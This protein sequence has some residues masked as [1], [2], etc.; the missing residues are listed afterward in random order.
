MKHPAE[1]IARSVRRRRLRRLAGAMPVALLVGLLAACSGSGKGASP[2]SSQAPN[3][4]ATAYDPN[5][6]LSYAA[7]M[8]DP[9]FFAFDPVKATIGDT[10][11]VLQLLDDSLLRQQPDGSLTPALAAAASIVNPQT[12]SVTLRPNVKFQDGTPLNSAAV[13]FTLLR[14][15]AANSIT[16]PAPIHDVSSVDLN[17]ELGLT[18]HLS[19]PDAGAFYPLLANMSTMPVSPTAVGRRDPNP[20][21]NPLGAGPFRITQYIPGQILVLT[22]NPTY[23][24]VEDIK[25]GGIK[26]VNESG[27]GPAAINALEAGT[28]DAITSDI[29]ELGA[30]SGGGIQTAITSS[31]TTKEYFP[32][33]DATGPLQNVKVRQALNYALDRNAINQALAQ[34][35]GEAAWAL[36]PSSSNLYPSDLTN[37]Y[38]YNPAKAKQLIAQAGYPSGLT[39]TIMPGLSQDLQRLA[40]IAQQ[41]WKAI[42]VNLQFKTTNP[43]SYVEDMFVKH[44]A[45]MTDANVVRSGLDA[46]S[47]LFTPGHLGDLCGYDSPTLDSM[48][49]QLS[50]LASTDPHYVQLWKQAQDFVVHN[51]LDVWAIWLPSVIAYN[52]SRV[53]GIQTV[54]PSV[55]AYPDF[56][57][58]YIKK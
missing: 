47:F 37:Y 45:N 22:R 40:L 21:T 43:S 7:D 33:C 12:I 49:T 30:L 3:G 16:F 50:A 51:A 24:D 58:A 56:F 46:I 42:G 32:L 23:W 10:G 8:S 27:S 11:A 35:K 1:P 14:N 34:G 17:G 25:L 29:T 36:V 20:V 18:I 4:S 28:V 2:S 13:K 53:G 54:F 15:S 26:F 39:L 6:V 48:L 55:T 38:A 19:K 44:Q 57:T 5:G 31:A 9:S 52:G 41:E